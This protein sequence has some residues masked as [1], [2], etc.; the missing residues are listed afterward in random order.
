M[1]RAAWLLVGGLLAFGVVI[2]CGEVEDVPAPDADA[3]ADAG[4]AGSTSCR[5]NEAQCG[6]VCANLRTDA[7]NCG[8]CG[9]ACAANEVCDLGRCAAGCST[10]LTQCGQ[11]CIE[12]SS[13]PANCGAC[14]KACAR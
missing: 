10:G 9:T 7:K 8:T 4:P 14:A 2:A 5:Q 11:S 3:G 13:D 12:T 6:T 1:G